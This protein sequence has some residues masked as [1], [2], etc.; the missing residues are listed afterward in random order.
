M[1]ELDPKYR[2]VALAVKD[3]FRYGDIVAYTWLYTQFKFEE[4]Q[5]G[6]K[7]SEYQD[8]QLQKMTAFH[9][10]TEECLKR[11][12]ILL[13]N[14]RTVGFRLAH[15]MEHAEIAMGGLSKALH[16]SF[17]TA[18]NQLAHTNVALLS[19]KEKR[20]RDEAIG[21]IGALTCFARVR[22]ITDLDEE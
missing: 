12:E 19:H 20:R 3:N 1:L 6:C 7:V 16:K 4:P 18:T 14:V 2:Q 11:H 8:F 22:R 21:K 9:G 15:P 5:D 13:V 17:R 10:L